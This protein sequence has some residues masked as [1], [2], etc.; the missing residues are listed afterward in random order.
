MHNILSYIT[1]MLPARAPSYAQAD[2]LEDGLPYAAGK[3]ILP[4]A[5]IY[6]LHLYM[7]W[8]YLVTQIMNLDGFIWS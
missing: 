4:P 8:S 7:V 5:P 3:Q 1:G 2:Y 6:R